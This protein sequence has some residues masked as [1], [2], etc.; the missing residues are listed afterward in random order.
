[1]LNIQC[2]IFNAQRIQLPSYLFIAFGISMPAHLFCI[3][4]PFIKN[5]VGFTLAAVLIAVKSQVKIDTS[6]L[7]NV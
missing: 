4:G 2:S 5:N 7:S 1:M 3:T 6:L